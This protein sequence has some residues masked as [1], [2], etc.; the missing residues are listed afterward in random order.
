MD[1]ERPLRQLLADELAAEH[2][3]QYMLNNFHAQHFDEVRNAFATYTAY[4]AGIVPLD[5]EHAEEHELRLWCAHSLGRKRFHKVLRDFRKNEPQEHVQTKFIVK[6]YLTWL[7]QSEKFYRSYIAMLSDAAGG[8]HELQLIA[9]LPTGDGAGLHAPRDITP[10]RRDTILSSCHRALISLGD[11]SRYRA[12]EKLDRHPDFGRAFGYYG[13]ATTIK[14]SAGVGHHQQAVICLEQRNHLRAIYHLYR[15]MTVAEPHPLAEKNLRLEIDQAIAAYDKGELIVKR[16][17]NDPDAAKLS[18]VG[19]FVRLQSMCY[20]GRPFRE[21]EQLEREVLAQLSNVLKQRPL[22]G[23]FY[24]MVSVNISAQHIAGERFQCKCDPTLHLTS[25]A[26][27]LIPVFKTEELR[28]SFLF[29]LRLNLKTFTTLL[30]LFCN[31][32]RNLLRGMVTH[33][34]P[35]IFKLTEICCRLLPE[36]RVYNNWLFTM[37]EMLHG[38]ANYEFVAESVGQF[39]P[40]Y[41]RAIDLICQAFPIWEFEDMNVVEY[42]LEED[43]ETLGFLPLLSDTM[44]Q[45]RKTWF[46]QAT[47]N[48]KPR[49]YDPGVVRLSVNEEMLYRMYDFMAGG[50]NIAEIDITP[51]HIQHPGTRVYYGSPDNIEA[52]TS[53]EPG[54]QPEPPP[55]KTVQPERVSYATAAAKGRAEK[56]VQRPVPSEPTMAKIQAQF[57]QAARMVHNLVEDDDEIAPVNDD[58]NPV[59][60]P[61]LVATAPAIVTNGELPMHGQDMAYDISVK[62]SPKIGTPWNN[63]YNARPKVTSTSAGAWRR[64]DNSPAATLTGQAE[65]LHSER[66]HTASKFSDGLSGTSSF[67]A[68][69]PTGSMASPVNGIPGG[70]ARVN[71]ASSA[72]S[73][74]SLGTVDPWASSHPVDPWAPRVLSDGPEMTSSLDQNNMS[75]ILLFGAGNSPWSTGVQPGFGHPRQQFGPGG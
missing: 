49:Y 38:V 65:R 62:S 47:G 52:L 24:R 56:A 55:K 41:G 40:I 73:K 11:L 57:A 23:A 61:Q 30:N 58:N 50:L 68:D 53:P 67:P 69:L 14:P 63:H 10:S 34:H 31:D 13:L 46:N 42:L 27:P 70:H 32:L 36:L 33:D 12:S 15:S 1:M 17:P 18:L 45:T 39:W 28:L 51:V 66:L 3:V 25:R 54:Y 64:P 2:T 9:H 72:R 71:S 5:F 44:P 16:A 7:K 48:Q 8:I 60:P 75:S 20:Q 35:L 6:A 37:V 21:H 74:N 29:Y 4:V 43:V 59:T 26:D 19:W 22:N